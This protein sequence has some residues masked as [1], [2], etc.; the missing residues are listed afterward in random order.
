MLANIIAGINTQERISADFSIVTTMINEMIPYS[1]E[2]YLGMAGDSDEEEM[3]LN[4]D[5]DDEEGEENSDEG[6]KK[7]VKE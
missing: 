1:L 6:P 5:E 4:D 2:A 3:E 7:K